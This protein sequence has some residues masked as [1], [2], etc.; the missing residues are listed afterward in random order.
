MDKTTDAPNTRLRPLVL[1]WVAL[2][3]LT[4]L[5]ALLGDALRGAAGLTAIVAALI[6]L[7]AWLVARA[8]LEAQ[9]CHVFIRRLVFV[10]IAYA[11]VL[12]V[13]T[14]RYGGTFAAWVRL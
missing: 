14:D 6:W 5:S 11:P 12:L 13:L 9:H 7:K 8:F 2:V 3:T 4:L 10:F 1:A